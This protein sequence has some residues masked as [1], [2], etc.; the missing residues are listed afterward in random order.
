[1]DAYGEDIN[2]LNALRVETLYSNTAIP[3]AVTLTGCVAL[4]F[5]LLDKNNT[6]AAFIWIGL[7]FFISFMRFL[8]VRRYHATKKMPD[9]YKR[10]LTLFMI[11]TVCSGLLLG[12]TPYIFIVNNDII[13]AG[14]LTMFILVLNSGSIGIYSAFN[15]VYYSFNVPAVLPLAVYLFSQNDVML[16]KLGVIFIAFILFIFIIQ[17]H[18]HRII[19]QMISIKLDNQNLLSSYEIDKSRID[20]LERMFNTNQKE[21]EVTKRRLLDCEE[22]LKQ[23]NK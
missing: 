22:N 7:L 19:K 13:N 1:M 14:L 9:E 20:V 2:K 11:G 16:N 18:A 12:S 21:L 4:F 3:V 17:Y 15:R 8:T 5:V 10:W 6:P 23:A